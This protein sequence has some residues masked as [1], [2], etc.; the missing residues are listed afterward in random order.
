MCEIRMGP[1]RPAAVSASEIWSNM[2]RT[3]GTATLFPNRRRAYSVESEG[4]MT[5]ESGNPMQRAIS[6][7]CSF[8]TLPLTQ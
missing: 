4:G 2:R 8:L 1:V 6:R 3:T 5:K 7:G